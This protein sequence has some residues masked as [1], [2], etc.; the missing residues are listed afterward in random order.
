MRP[1]R[2]LV[3]LFACIIL[4][5]WGFFFLMQQLKPGQSERLEQLMGNYTIEGDVKQIE[6]LNY[7]LLDQ[8][9]TTIRVHIDQ[10]TK[11]LGPITPGDRIRAQMS[12]R[13]RAVTIRLVN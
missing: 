4:L 3:S 9:G 10:Q 5:C 12:Q 8:D 6:A 13:N 11:M 2:K 1:I 7:L